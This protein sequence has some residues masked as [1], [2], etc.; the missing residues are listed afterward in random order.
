[1]QP[2]G[3]QGLTT[4]RRVNAPPA[5]SSRQDLQHPLRRPKPCPPLR[6]ALH[7]WFGRR[8]LDTCHL[9]R[10]AW[11]YIPHCIFHRLRSLRLLK[12]FSNPPTLAWPPPPKSFTPPCAPPAPPAPS[13]HQLR[14]A[15]QARLQ[16]HEAAHHVRPQ[17]EARVCHAHA[18]GDAAAR[19][20][21]A[22]GNGSHS[23]GRVPSKRYVMCG[24]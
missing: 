24:S 5:N 16:L 19:V 23:G 8:L 13:P 6:L 10:R 2:S 4:S 20:L 1:M 22:A 17:R 14:E 3:G 18:H 9:F 21:E 15:A 12:S 11:A 7:S